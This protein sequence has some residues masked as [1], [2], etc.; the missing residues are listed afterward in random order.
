MS[1][2]VL[3]C[4]RLPDGGREAF[5]EADI[6]VT[7][8]ADRATGSL[9]DIIEPYAGV[10][11]H[12]PHLV[13]AEAVAAADS[14]RVVGRAGVGVDNIDVP[15]CTERG[16]LVMNLP[17]G[18][19][20]SAAEHT[21]AL[22]TSLARNIPQASAALRA[23]TWDRG[24]FLGVELNKK[25]LGIVG[26]GRIG[27]EVARRAQGLGMTVLGTDPF[28]SAS[29]AAD[30][31][32]ELR[33]FDDLLPDV[34]FLTVHVPRTPET[35]GLINS[36]SIGRMPAGVRIVNCARGGV[37]D[38]AALLKGLE[39]GH[40]AGAAC[41][42]FETEPTD[43]VGLLAHP[44][45]VGTPHLGGATQEARQRVGEG[46][47][48]QVA[49]YLSRGV[50]R[51]AINVKALPPGEHAAVAPYLP[52]VRR[53]GS[54]LSQSYSGIDRLRIEYFGEIAAATLTPLTANI[55][56]GAL[57]AFLDVEVNEVNAEQLARQRGLRVDAVTGDAWPGYSSL[58]RVTAHAEGADHAVA[59]T[60]FGR[61]RTRLV[62][63]DGLAI[64]IA[65]RGTMLVFLNEDAPGVIGRVGTLLAER[66]VNIADMSLGRNS[67]GG[68]AI[69]ALVLDHALEAA[70]LDA[71]SSLP[72]MHWVRQV[73]V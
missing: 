11:V 43:N 68:D 9:S 22:V 42:V 6:E 48:R 10:I 21:I 55:I 16:V 44:H 18:N 26:L 29:A 70:D 53:M 49:E 31:G 4:G 52:L 34:D 5:E 56:A 72:N 73:T 24:A 36:A 41:D 39:S 45:F 50:I 40:V 12:S 47:A 63:I 61:D 15:A 7:H 19:T 60:V 27:R 38:E 37:V 14:L 8:L 2:K 23:G 64:D 71:V 17:W 65:P 57:S 58:V 51:H 62:E 54:F 66:G 35:T 67:S 46:I 13:D 59:G 20:V 33:E 1:E 30:L 69:A 28:L 3:V 25:R 32:I